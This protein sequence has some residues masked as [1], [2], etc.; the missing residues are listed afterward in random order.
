MKQTAPY[1]KTSG[2]KHTISREEILSRLEDPAFALVN[3]MPKETF[4]AGHIPHSINLPLSEVEAKARQIF[5][6]LS[7]EISVYC[8]GPT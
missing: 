8:M 3:V 2:H 4:E 5:P 6:V 1:M 7:R